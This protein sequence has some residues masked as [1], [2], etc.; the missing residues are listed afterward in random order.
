MDRTRTNYTGYLYS[1]PVDIASR[2]GAHEA[3]RRDTALLA[4]ELRETLGRRHPPAARRARA[5]P[6][7]QLAVLGRLDREGPASIS[8]LAAAEPHAP[9][10]D[11]ADG[12]RP[13]GGGPR[14]APPDPARRAALV[15]RA[16]ARRPRGAASETRARREDWLTQ[17]A[18]PRARRPTSASSCGEALRLLAPRRR[19]LGI[20]RDPPLARVDRHVVDRG[21]APSP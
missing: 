19:R 6:L 15:R 12:P 16:H 17:R 9:A 14:L 8:D 3:P 18:G 2:L 21:V 5:R 20:D 10:V 11:G 1:S 7:G 4:H 13:R